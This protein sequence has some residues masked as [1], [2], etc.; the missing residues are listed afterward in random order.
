[1]SSE[2][3]SRMNYAKN[4]ERERRGAGGVDLSLSRADGQ[5]NLREE[6]D[7]GPPAAGF[8]TSGSLKGDSN[9]TARPS[10]SLRQVR[11]WNPRPSAPRQQDPATIRLPG[12]RHEF[13]GHVQQHKT[14]ATPRCA[15]SSQ[16][17][18]LVFFKILPGT[19]PATSSLWTKKNFNLEKRRKKTDGEWNS[20]LANKFRPVL[21]GR[22][23]KLL[24][25]T[26]IVNSVPDQRG[27]R[28]C[29]CL[30]NKWKKR[31]K[32]ATVECK[33]N[34]RLLLSRLIYARGSGGRRPGSSQTRGR[35]RR[36]RKKRTAKDHLLLLVS[37]CCCCWTVFYLKIQSIAIVSIS[38][39]R[40]VFIFPF[41]SSFSSSA[42][43][44]QQAAWRLRSSSPHWPWPGNDPPSHYPNGT[45][46]QFRP[47]KVF[48]SLQ[49]F[50]S[51]DW[52]C[53]ARRRRWWWWILC[54]YG[55]DG[56]SP[57]G[58]PVA[59][60]AALRHLDP[61]LGNNTIAALH[62]M[63]KIYFYFFS[64][65][66]WRR[67]TFS[68]WPS[69]RFPSR[70]AETSIDVSRARLD[71][72]EPGRPQQLKFILMILIIQWP[73]AYQMITALSSIAK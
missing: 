1:M 60:W 69:V 9:T 33:T 6:E 15:S 45:K 26:V 39:S 50:H 22:Q 24:I 27:A 23:M 5:P 72:V 25:I 40:Y 42:V 70:W 56:V 20:T 34:G 55:S 44:S 46:F 49:I 43:S 47:I 17:P 16:W 28:D 53:L 29:C 14:T 66:V 62:F 41:S 13:L 12:R 54:R 2:K 61:L 58:R 32:K 10:V 71:T 52:F 48:T 37:R 68:S 65:F 3:T 11:K 59:R 63:K 7:G 30:L 8:S 36:R 64:F 67:K 4:K 21:P 57:D 73:I 38:S 51:P 19:C 35:R 31:R 18:V